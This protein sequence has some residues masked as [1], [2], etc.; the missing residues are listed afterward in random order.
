M[1]SSRVPAVDFGH[2]RRIVVVELR[3]RVRNLLDRPLQLVALAVAGLFLFGVVAAV[4][5]FAYAGGGRLG[6]PAVLGYAG[7]AAGGLFALVAALVA[8]RTVSEN[9]EPDNLDGMLTTVP[10]GE[11]FAGLLGVEL[12]GV[13]VYGLLPVLVAAG[14]LAAG[15]GSLAV[16]VTVALAAG[17]LVAFGVL[18]GMALGFAV[19][20]VAVRSELVARF[21][22]L[23]WVVVFVA[24]FGVFATGSQGA[25]F[26][27]VVGAFARPP[28]TYFADLALLPVHPAASALRAAA[29]VAVT[30]V[31]AAAA[32]VAGARLAG[33]LWY[34][35][36][37]HAAETT[38]TDATSL[39]AGPLGRLV[40]RRTA[41]V[42]R[43]SWLRARR[44]PMKLVYVAYPAFGLLGPLSV[45]FQ[46]GEVSRTLPVLCALYATW[47]GGAAFAL[48]P[49]GDEGAALP[50]TVTS[51]VGG[52]TFV[53][54]VALPGAAL[55]G[56]CALALSVGLGV[57]SGLP[58]VRLATLAGTAVA[59]GVGAPALATG[60]GA[61]LPKFEASRITR[62]RSAVV[63]SLFAFAAYSLALLGLSV[64]GVVTQLPLFADGVGDLLGLAPAVLSAVGLGVTVVLVAAAGL[65]SSAYAARRFDRFELS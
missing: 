56:A 27:P 25:V 8:F 26:A 42:A 53:A 60:V 51:G 58:P 54:G 17:L 19:K 6:D 41:W 44:A 63:P 18:T 28:L 23:L 65:L 13:T 39:D 55:G 32:F 47:A 29:A 34:A 14:A 11:V 46:T 4:G 30:A 48:N 31:G 40:G 21:R 49:L 36:R 20:N 62:S 7:Q 37:A 57:V 35:D 24:Y 50:V 3:R 45:A 12:V 43:K 2:V 9:S 10:Y 64:P 38:G 5:F 61:A 15:S 33:A 22:V 59:L 52:W 16:G 1:S